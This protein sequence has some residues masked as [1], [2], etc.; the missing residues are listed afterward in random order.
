VRERDSKSMQG[1]AR[2]IER[3]GRRERGERRE[4]EI[5]KSI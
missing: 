4:R 1:T 2:D 5:K 3:G